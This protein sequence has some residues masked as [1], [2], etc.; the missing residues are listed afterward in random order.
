[1]KKFIT[2]S[3]FA[4]LLALTASAQQK[5]KAKG[6]QKQH[7]VEQVQQP[8]VQSSALPHDEALPDD[9]VLSEVQGQQVKELNEEMKKRRDAIKNNDL[10]S[11]E[12]KKEQMRAVKEERKTRLKQILS[13]E[14]YARMQVKHKGSENGMRGK[15]WDKNKDKNHKHGKGKK[16]SD[17][18]IMEEVKPVKQAP[19]LIPKK[20]EAKTQGTTVPSVDP[21]KQHEKFKGKK[22]SK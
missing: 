7:K 17:D 15:G 11:K 13:E 14:Q 1:M 21:V 10:L 19:V 5:G 3:I 6:K 18:T 16:G 2:L 8:V 4:A 22:G 9:I 12:Q 20:E